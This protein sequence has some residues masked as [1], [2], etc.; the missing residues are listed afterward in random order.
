MAEGFTVYYETIVMRRAGFLSEDEM[1]AGAASPI[2]AVE[3]RPGRLLQSASE[4][5]Y[6]SWDQGPFGG[7]PATTVSYYDKGAV[8]AL[9]LD[10]A[11]RK[12]TAGARS[13]DDVMRAL[14]K[15]YYRDKGRGF[16]EAELRAVCERIAGESLSEVFSYADTAKPVDYAKYLGYAGLALETVA[17]PLAAHAFALRPDR[18]SG[19]LAPDRPPAGPDSRAGRHP[20]GLAAEII[21]GHHTQFPNTSVDGKRQQMA[22]LDYNLHLL[23]KIIREL[24]MVSPNSG[25]RLTPV[26]VLRYHSRDLIRPLASIGDS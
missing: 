15:E 8:I 9:L 4:S 13:L 22:T 24:R 14:Y 20:P 17:A 18:A 16:T 10:L 6:V 21:G 1:L 26:S 25:G 23:T 2:T 12:A 7:D 19:A 11:I 5:S 3:R